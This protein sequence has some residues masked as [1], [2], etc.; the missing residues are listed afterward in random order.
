MLIKSASGSSPLKIILTIA[1]E[2]FEGVERNTGLTRP[3][4]ICHA[5]RKQKTEVIRSTHFLRDSLSFI[6]IPCLGIM[7]RQARIDIPGHLYHVIA[8]GIERRKMDGKGDIC[9]PRDSW[10]PLNATGEDG[11]PFPGRNGL[12][13][14]RA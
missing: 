6:F 1:I 12:L 10:R 14:P 13:S 8:R 9:G 11:N 2:I 5:T 3:P 4:I 7:P